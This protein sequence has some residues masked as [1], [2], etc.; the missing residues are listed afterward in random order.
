ML[1]KITESG[2]YGR[3]KAKVFDK[4]IFNFM[5]FS[6]IIG[7]IFRKMLGKFVFKGRDKMLRAI[8][9]EKSTHC[10]GGLFSVVGWDNVNKLV[11]GEEAWQWIHLIMG[12]GAVLSNSGLDCR[13]EIWEEMLIT[14]AGDKVV[15]RDFSIISAEGANWEGSIED[16]LVPSHI[17][18][19]EDGP[20]N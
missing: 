16:F 2:I 12:Q 14:T 8:R 18:S 17:K 19:I 13:Q 7:E 9:E 6:G 20:T 15:W 5:D 3:V 1:I 4:L 11:W 10:F